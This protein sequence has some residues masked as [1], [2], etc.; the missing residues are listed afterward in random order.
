VFNAKARSRGSRDAKTPR[1]GPSGRAR[2]RRATLLAAVVVVLAL[3]VLVGQA[4]AALSVSNPPTF[5]YVNDENGAD[6]QPGQKDLNSQAVANPTPGD[7]WVSW[8]WD[9]TSLSGGNTGDACALFDTNKNSKVNFAIC[10]TIQGNPAVQAPVSPRVYTC[11]DGKVDRCTS[12]Y[13]EVSPINSACGTNT[14]AT[15]P[16]HSGKKDTQAICH[17]D[18]ADVGGS[19]TANLVNTCSYPSQQPTSAPSDCV[20]IPRDAFLRIT[21]VATPNTGSFP[22]RLGLTTETSPAVVYTASGSAT[23]DYIAIRS[24]KPYKL[25]EDVPTNWAIDTPSPSCTGASGSN[26][27]FSG[28]T[29][30]GIQAAAD[31]T[32]TCT[33]RDKQQA[34]AIVITKQRSGTT[35]KLSGAEFSVDG[36]GTYTS[37]SDGTVCV[38]GLSIGS[39]TV[40]E[41]KAPNGH[42]LPATTSQSVAVTAAGT[43]TTGTQATVTFNDP[44]KLGTV[45]IVKTGVG[46]AALPGATFTIYKNVA[47]TTGPRGTGDDVTTL[48]CTTGDD[49]KCSISDVPLGDYWLVETGIP[50]GYTAVADRAFTIDVGSS[51]GTGDTETFELTDSAA[52]GRINIHKT[53]IGGL[54]LAGATFTLYDDK[55]LNAGQ[56]GATRGLED[57]S[58]GK[59]CTTDSSGDCSFTDVPP[60]DYWIVET[61]TPAGYDTADEKQVNVGLGSTGGAGATVGVTISDPVVPGTVNIHKY[62]IDASDLA[63]AT[64]TLYKDNVTKGGSRGAE[65]TITTKTCTTVADG[66]CSITAVTPGDYWVVETGVPDGYSAAP[67]QLVNVGI[68]TTAHAGDT[69]ALS[70]TD[71]PVPGTVS[72]TKKDDANNALQGA[73]FTLYTDV[74]PVGGTRDQTTTDP[75]TNPVKKCTTGA[76]GTC[77]I[78][79]VAPGKYWLVE[80]GVPAHYDK[81][82]EQAITVALGSAPGVGDTVPV[83]LVDPRKHRVVVLVCHEG[84]DTLAAR[85][86]TVGGVTKQSIGAGSLTAAQQKALCDTGGA[87]FGDI[88]GHP[89]VTAT[90]K[91]AGDH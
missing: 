36:S 3:P 88:S 81:A 70:F 73:E 59:T 24:D 90:V 45:N 53:G 52:P 6:D 2:R 62:G 54:A 5:T 17:V 16:F 77:D 79:G 14:N 43:C 61:T 26:G 35:V 15:D 19:S 18:L 67:D 75:V 55:G 68:G 83:S 78:T 56:S 29:I 76:T 11:G 12:T 40:T 1:P 30:T 50:A 66:T 71:T 86:V 84:T 65:D 42:D 64:F 89:D 48:K 37:G 41:T 38:A 22:F 8:Q 74:A 21:K 4:V 32:I 82:D 58:T 39:H 91:L 49:G 25:K 13:A 72:I 87:A 33:F 10:V 46:G 20:L 34:G 60:G 69:D 57:T 27:T 28:D 44:L 80:T 7:L 47:P 51:P 31:N 23:S 85:D 9:E 63:G